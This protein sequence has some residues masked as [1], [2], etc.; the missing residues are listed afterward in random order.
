MPS[1]TR[2]YPTAQY[3]Y[4]DLAIIVYDA[5]QV[6]NTTA[7]LKMITEFANEFS[8]HSAKCKGILVG[9]R[10]DQVSN[11]KQAKLD[12][13]WYMQQTS[14]MKFFVT[15]FSISCSDSH[16]TMPV[17]LQIK[18]YMHELLAR[19]YKHWANNNLKEQQKQQ[20]AKHNN[21][22]CIMC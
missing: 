18:Q 3:K 14:G 1:F 4:S 20:A 8:R 9:T 12:A 10:M 6:G 21:S 15:S 16:A 22:S 13:Q 19:S 17:L 11:V 7:N 2:K 5:S